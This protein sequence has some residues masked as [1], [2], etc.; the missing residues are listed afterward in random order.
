MNGFGRNAICRHAL[1]EGIFRIARDEQDLEFPIAAADR[2]KKSWAIHFRHHHIGNDEVDRAFF[3]SSAPGAGADDATIRMN[4]QPERSNQ[5]VL[6]GLVERVT[7]HNEE[8][9]F[10]VLRINLP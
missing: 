3:C 2:L 4:P 10:C 1:H 6:A 5:E 7:Y 9:G 8:N